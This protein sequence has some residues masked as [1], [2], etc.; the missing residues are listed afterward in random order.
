M[1]NSATTKDPTEPQV[2]RFTTL[3]ISVS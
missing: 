2:Y 3:W 1:Y